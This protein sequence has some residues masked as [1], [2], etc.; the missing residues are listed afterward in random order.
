MQ[1]EISL[2]RAS[3]G[4]VELVQSNW[5]DTGIFF[6]WDISVLCLVM[7]QNLNVT[8]LP[9]DIFGQ[10]DWIDLIS[11]GHLKKISVCDQKNKPRFD[12]ILLVKK[13]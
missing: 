6:R 12:I 8:V 3:R 1:S 10:Y 9:S 2:R 5:F 4:G 11:S 7:V 13:T